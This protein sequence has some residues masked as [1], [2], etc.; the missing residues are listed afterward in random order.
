MLPFAF[1]A[2]VWFK[3]VGVLGLQYFP[4]T[5][6]LLLA[7]GVFPIRDHYY[8]PMINPVHLRFSLHKDR[9]LLAL[10]LNIDE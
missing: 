8:E 4:A 10:D 5:K 3:A 1:V 6:R 9:N 7:V 2:A